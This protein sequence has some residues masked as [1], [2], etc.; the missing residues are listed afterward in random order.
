MPINSSWLIA[1]ALPRVIFRG[2]GLPNIR[3]V[4]FPSPVRSSWR[5][6]RRQIPGMWEGERECWGIYYDETDEG[7][8]EVNWLF[9]VAAALHMGILDQPNESFRLEKHGYRDGY[10]MPD[11]DGR[12]HADFN[13]GGEDC[14]DVSGKWLNDMPDKL[15][16]GLDIDYVHQKGAKTVISHDHPRT[17][18]GYEYFAS[19]AAVHIRNEKKRLLYMYTPI[20][21]D[22]KD[23]E[24]GVRIAVKVVESMVEDLERQ[25]GQ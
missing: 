2:N 22:S 9:P 21:H 8:E 19:L 3:L 17:L 7:G 10:D 16:T 18:C 1:N 6:I 25:M 24:H 15:S 13:E 23:I 11:I 5:W 20:E 12:Y 4:V 14:S